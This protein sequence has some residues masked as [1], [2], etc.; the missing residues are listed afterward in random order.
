MTTATTKTPK[1]ILER[2]GRIQEFHRN[3]KLDAAYELPGSD[4]DPPPN[5]F[6]IF[7]GYPKIPLPKNLHQCLGR[8]HPPNLSAAA[9]KQCRKARSSL[10]KI[11]K[12]WLPGSFM[13]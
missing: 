3:T 2:V 7:D 1:E 8:N 13:G 4:N 11:C 9:W 10:R 12:L 5:A 6:R